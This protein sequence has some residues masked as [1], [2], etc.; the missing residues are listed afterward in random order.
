MNA[1]DIAWAR[2]E[3]IS[4]TEL[5]IQCVYLTEVCRC[6]TDSK[7]ER[8]STVEYM[9]VSLYPLMERIERCE[10]RKEEREREK[11]EACVVAGPPVK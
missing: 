2:G 7:R 5:H 11:V 6:H 1:I 4:E 8:D 9:S 3:C 10:R